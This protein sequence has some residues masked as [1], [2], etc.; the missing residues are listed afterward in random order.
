MENKTVIGPMLQETLDRIEFERIESGYYDA[1]YEDG[2]I[3]KK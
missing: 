1:L 3:F 2:G